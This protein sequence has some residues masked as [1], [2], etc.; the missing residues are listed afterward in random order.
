[1]PATYTI[2]ARASVVFAVPQ[3][4]AFAEPEVSVLMATPD[5]WVDPHDGWVLAAVQIQVMETPT[6]SPSCIQFDATG[7]VISPIPDGESQYTLPPCGVSF[8]GAF[9][10]PIPDLASQYDALEQGRDEVIA[11]NAVSDNDIAF[12]DDYNACGFVS[13]TA[14]MNYLGYSPVEPY[15]VII[16]A[17]SAGIDV[18]AQQPWQPIRQAAEGVGVGLI[19]ANFQ[20][21]AGATTDEIAAFL[22]DPKQP[23]VIAYVMIAD[24]ERGPTGGLLTSSSPP[25]GIEHWVVVT[26]I[27]SDN[28]WISIMNPLNNRIEYYSV[29]DF[30]AARIRNYEDDSQIILLTRAEDNARQVWCDNRITTTDVYGWCE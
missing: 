3:V 20:S 14:S 26:Q 17:A 15:Q 25:Q 28:Q 4:A 9:V 19:D 16:A 11:F 21:L 2:E 7:A 24:S 1:V 23:S 22:R 27:S 10:S 12:T 30:E 6:P 13:V 8:D 5:P 18:G 29:A